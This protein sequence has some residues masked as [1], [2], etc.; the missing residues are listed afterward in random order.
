MI[1]GSGHSEL[2]PE[3]NSLLDTL[4]H[5]VR[6]ELIYYFEHCS[7][8]VTATFEEVVTYLL[9]QFP[10]TSRK[11]LEVGLVH[12]HLPKLSDRDWIDYDVQSREIRYY[13]HETAPELLGVVHAMF[14]PN[15]SPKKE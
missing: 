7:T 13:G 1:P 12:N 10:D 14:D 11:Q 6:R 5:R 9:N 3:I 4:G 8:A 2:V 15:P